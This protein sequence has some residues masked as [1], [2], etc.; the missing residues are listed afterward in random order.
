MLIRKKWKYEISWKRIDRLQISTWKDIVHHYTLEKCKLKTQWDITIC[1]AG[2]AKEQINA[3][4][5]DNWM[6]LR[7]MLRGKA[8]LQ[9]LHIIWFHLFNTLEMKKNCR[10]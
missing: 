1:P 6:N 7:P 5:C 2:T 8:S 10:N 3:D 4:A 9:R